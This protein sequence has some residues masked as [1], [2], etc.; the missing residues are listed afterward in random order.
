LLGFATPNSEVRNWDTYGVLKLTLA[1][2]NYEWEFI[3]VEGQTFRDSGSG[4]CHN[5]PSP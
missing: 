1:P 2:G 3:P 5:V 4:V